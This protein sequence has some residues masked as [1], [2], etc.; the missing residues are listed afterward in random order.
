ISHILAGAA[1]QA[2]P[3]DIRR[4][5]EVIHANLAEPLS[6]AQIAQRAGMN[7]RTLQKGFQ[8]AFGKSPMTVLRDARLDTAHYQLT[9]RQERPSVTTAA[10][11][12]GFSHLGRFSRDYKARFGHL[13]SALH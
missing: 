10:Y 3:R 9:A 12:C 5:L 6:S 7:I 1:R 13:P 4:A 11:S 2:L 8:R